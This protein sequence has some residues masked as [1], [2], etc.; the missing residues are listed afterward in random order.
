MKTKFTIFKNQIAGVTKAAE[1]FTDLLENV[2]T[3]K[4]LEFWSH[5]QFKD[6]ENRTIQITR[7]YLEEQNMTFED[8]VADWLANGDIEQE[9]YSI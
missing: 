6:S 5:I 4:E 9:I 7:E 3:K 8:C 2:M 1:N